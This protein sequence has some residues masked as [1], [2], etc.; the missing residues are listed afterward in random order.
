MVLGVDQR[1][2]QE[3]LRQVDAE[4]AEVEPAHADLSARLTKLR[5]AKEALAALVSTNGGGATV[6][7]DTNLLIEVATDDEMM[8]MAP[9]RDRI[10]RIVEEAGKPLSS[11]AIYEQMKQRGW[12]RGSPENSVYEAARRLAVNNGGSVK[13]VGRNLYE[14]VNRHEMAHDEGGA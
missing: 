8:A 2:V 12:L 11:S 7:A 9:L 6:V 4:L 3:A 1:A 10:A 13:R 14:W 5:R